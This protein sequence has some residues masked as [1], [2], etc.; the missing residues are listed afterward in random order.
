MRKSEHRDQKLNVARYCVVCVVTLFG[1]FLMPLSC[2]VFPFSATVEAQV[3][4]ARRRVAHNAIRAHLSAAKSGASCLRRDLQQGDC[5]VACTRIF[6][7]KLTLA[8]LQ[9]ERDRAR[10]Q[11]AV[12]SQLQERIR[13][14]REESSELEL[15]RTRASMERDQAR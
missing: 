9:F 15:E 10:E 14:L 6:S 3:R 11:E 8:I 2:F 4:V 7:S 12:I 5:G 13:V 1:T